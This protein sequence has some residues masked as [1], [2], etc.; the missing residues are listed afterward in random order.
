MGNDEPRVDQRIARIAIIPILIIALLGGIYFAL[1]NLRQGR[2]DRRNATRLAIFLTLTAVVAWVLEIP[3]I[4]ILFLLLIPWLAGLV[5]I[6]YLA[7]EPFVRRKWPQVLITWTRILSGEWRDPLVARDA[8]VGILFGILA[9]CIHVFGHSLIPTL[10]GFAEIEPPSSMSV[11]TA[12]SSRILIS[13]LLQSLILGIL[14]SLVIIFTLFLMR[15]LLRNQKAAIAVCVFLFAFT[16]GPA[17]IPCFATLLAS[18]CLTI[19][20]LMR[21]GLL[22][23]ILSFFVRFLLQG[24]PVT[25]QTD[26][27]Y[28]P[29]G[30]FTLTIFAAIVLY[31]FHT[32]LGGRPLFGTHRL[33]E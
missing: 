14:L 8:L 12:M 24:F 9:Y 10:L 11:Y 17:N 16:A 25:L 1:K 27:W 29:N 5:W 2:G 22:T 33:D 28:A 6:I 18:S 31:A 4:W 3:Q 23:C 21:F 30:F 19:Y 7:I 13:G 15:L 26:A 32:S 20:L